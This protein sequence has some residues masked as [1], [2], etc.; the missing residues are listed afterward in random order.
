MKNRVFS[1]FFILPSFFFAQKN[2]TTSSQLL[3][4]NSTQKIFTRTLKHNSKIM[5]IG[6]RKNSRRFIFKKGKTFAAKRRKK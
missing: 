4:T 6:P 2:G 1:L 3:N 5:K